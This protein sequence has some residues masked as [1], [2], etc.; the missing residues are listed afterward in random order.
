[1]VKRFGTLFICLALLL[2]YG[3]I[4][5]AAADNPLLALSADAAAVVASGGNTTV[6][7]D[8]EDTPNVVSVDNGNGTQTVYIFNQPVRDLAAVTTA[9]SS[10]TTTAIQDAFVSSTF[11]SFNFGS[12]TYAFIGSHATYGVCREYVKFTGLS[13]LNIDQDR[14]ISAYYHADIM[15]MVTYPTAEVYF[16]SADWNESTINWNNK[17]DYSTSEILT[18]LNMVDYHNNATQVSDFYIT[19]AVK[20][21]LQGLPNYGVMIK[22]RDDSFQV[23]LATHESSSALSYLAISY[24]TTND[25]SYISTPSSSSRYG[26]KGIISGQK[27]YVYN[28]KSGKFLGVSTASAGS[29]VIQQN[30]TGAATQQWQ[31]NYSSSGDYYRLKLVA[32]PQSNSPLYLQVNGTVA[33]SNC[34]LKT[35]V[36]GTGNNQRWRIQ[37]NWDGSYRLQTLLNVTYAASVFGALTSAGALCCINPHTVDFAMEDDWTIV[38]VNKGS[39]SLYSFNMNINTTTLVPQMQTFLNGMGYS[40]VHR[41]ST[42]TSFET[43]GDAYSQLQTDSIFGFFGHG[44]KS[45]LCFQS[46]DYGT[47]WT[48]ESDITG[49]L[50]TYQYPVYPV[51][52][53]NYN[54]LAGLELFISTGCQSGQSSSND[55]GLIGSVYDR[56]AHFATASVLNGLN[57]TANYS[58]SYWRLTVIMNLSVGKNIYDA[59]NAGDEY[60]YGAGLDGN[61]P[62]RHTLGDNNLKLK[63]SSTSASPSNV[64]TTNVLPISKGGLEMMRL[65]TQFD[66]PLPISFYCDN[67]GTLFGYYD[68]SMKLVYFILNEE[69]MEL[70]NTIVNTEKALETIEG[71]ITQTDRSLHDYKVSYS[72]EYAKTFRVKLQNEQE[73]LTLVCKATADEKILV[74]SFFVHEGE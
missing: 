59:L 52:G 32:L 51:A 30:Y 31:M 41:P 28:K 16:N 36:S 27:Y 1:M 33:S 10:T 6:L 54:Q 24:Y 73:T 69:G 65:D 18:R 9:G 19:R 34:V 23:K 49:T 58:D 63:F 29:S 22:D 38:P 37:R 13:S 71:F 11:P 47:T 8:Y 20:G 56:G 5:G 48:D 43:A 67:A 12:Y 35:A 15:S 61:Y 40:A 70:G 55:L 64:C 66:Q 4:P 25:S 17:P 21:W 46:S 68:D 44:M 7:P 2:L 60:L 26:T 72:N 74:T 42:T 14:V 57:D 3:S 39:A 50:S 53:M 45:H 62:C